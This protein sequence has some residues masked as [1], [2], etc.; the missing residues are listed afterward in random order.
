MFI[1]TKK[2][3]L[4]FESDGNVIHDFTESRNRK[5]LPLRKAVHTGFY[6]QC[7]TAIACAVIGIALSDGIVGKVYAGVA[8]FCVVAVAFFALGGRS[9][10]KLA[11]CILDLVYA[12]FGFVIGGTALYY[13][14]ALLCIAVLG[15]VMSLIAGYFRD[16]LMGYSP[17]MLRAGRDYK[18]NRKLP[19]EEPKNEPPP[20]PPEP[21]KSELME[22]AEAFMEILK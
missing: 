5:A 14:G 19:A 15:A 11:S 8:A 22:V 4:Y 17:Y 1:K 10:E 2:R 13:C 12:V 6:I 9:W 7:V 16:W 20:P 21:E 3:L 18:L